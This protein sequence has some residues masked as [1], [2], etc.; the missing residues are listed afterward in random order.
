MV[1]AMSLLTLRG[2]A[3]CHHH[4]IAFHNL[5]GEGD[6]VQFNSLHLALNTAGVCPS[7]QV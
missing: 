1:M 7:R 3:S 2:T 5:K 6:T 4:S